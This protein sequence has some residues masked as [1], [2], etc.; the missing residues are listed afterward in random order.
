MQLI[1]ADDV[2]VLARAAFADPEHFKQK[3]IDLAVEALTME[4]VAATLGRVL[5]KSVSAQSVP[6]DEAIKA[7][8]F[9]GWVRSQE[10]TNE[11]GYRADMPALNSALGH[12]GIELTPFAN[13]IERHAR[14]IHIDT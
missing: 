3:N 10:W 11:V 9:P 6:P 13:W 12:Y 4:E 1:A 2:G 14:E 7:G 5:G 8:L